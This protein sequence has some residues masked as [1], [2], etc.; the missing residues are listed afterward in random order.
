MVTDSMNTL[1]MVH[2]QVNKQ[3]NSDILSNIEK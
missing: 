1:K 3:G 2:I